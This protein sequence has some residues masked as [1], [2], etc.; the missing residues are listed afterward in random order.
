MNIVA[1]LEEIFRDIFD[2]E[3][4]VLAL[5]M[6]IADLEDWDSLTQINII[7][8]IKKEYRIDFS[9]EETTKFKK[10]EDIVNCIQSKI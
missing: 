8:A 4:L 10:I 6:D 3:N 9:L 5:S 2:D 7:V 1:K